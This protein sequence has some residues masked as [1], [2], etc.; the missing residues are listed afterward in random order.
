M[1]RLARALAVVLAIALVAGAAVGVAVVRRLERVTAER[2]QALARIDALRAKATLSAD[3]ACWVIKHWFHHG[4]GRAGRRP[5]VSCEGRVSEVPRGLRVDRVFTESDL[6][7]GRLG[8]DLCLV[9]TGAW[10]VLGEASRYG[11]CLELPGGTADQIDATL[12]AELAASVRRTKAQLGQSIETMGLAPEGCPPGSALAPAQLVLADAARLVAGEEGQG[13]V[14]HDPAFSLC[15][16]PDSGV[17]DAEL[18]D[19]VCGRGRRLEWTHALVHELKVVRP[20][21]IDDG[22]FLGGTVEGQVA[23]VE[24]SKA[25]AVCRVAVGLQLP[26]TVV[27]RRGSVEVDLQL[28]FDELVRTGLEDA[29]RRL[30]R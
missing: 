9:R 4:A 12:R 5:L 26:E 6:L 15:D 17:R 20:R 22:R 8:H 13:L 11:G 27:G 28:R 18:A 3:E 21:V 29:K 10:E 24:L 25:R 7:Q 23:L 14:P 2:S 1:R 30:T 19:F 16:P